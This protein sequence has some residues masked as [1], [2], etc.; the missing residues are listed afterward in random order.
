MQDRRPTQPPHATTIEDGSSSGSSSDRGSGS[1]SGCSSSSTAEASAAAMSRWRCWWQGAA[2]V[3]AAL[4]SAASASAA[5]AAWPAAVTVAHIG[6][7]SG[8]IGLLGRSGWQW[9]QRWQQLRSDNALHTAVVRLFGPH[10]GFNCACI[11]EKNS[12]RREGSGLPW[13]SRW[14]MQG[15]SVWA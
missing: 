9:Q 3:A 11:R 4:S 6:T 10:H 7:S 2:A 14:P 1:G 15:Y 12:T 8:G 13:P 5:S